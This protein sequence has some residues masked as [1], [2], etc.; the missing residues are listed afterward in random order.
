MDEFEGKVAVVTGGG[1]GIGRAL[2]VRFASLGM[3]V[4]LGDVDAAGMAATAAE[5][6]AV[7]PTADP[8][9]VTVDVRDAAQVDA[10]ADAGFEAFGQV[11]VLCNNAG[12]FVGGYL[13]DRPT[14]ELE[15]SLGV[16]LWGILHGIRAFVPR[17]IAQDTEGHV[18]NTAS[19]AGLFGSPF[20]GPYNVAKFAAFAASE[21]LANDLIASGSKLRA[22][23]LCPGIIT[24]NIA[25]DAQQRPGRD[26]VDSPDDQRF[27]TDLLADMVDKGKDPSVVADR[28]VDSIL[29][30]DFLILT[31][32][33]HADFLR[34]RGTELAEHQLPHVADY[35]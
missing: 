18:V 1:S 34:E 6:A 15:L 24:T 11:D 10:F 27:V 17:M 9:S 35:S 19:I 3:R 4:V 28:V 29:A 14:D 33:H 5:I 22:S 7:I 26:G 30:Q 25:R 16:N 32:D 12:V 31:H 23:V 2:A 8:R 21:A 20:S 13:W